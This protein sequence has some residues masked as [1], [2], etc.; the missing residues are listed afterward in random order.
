MGRGES[1]NQR[2]VRNDGAGR[3][4]CPGPREGRSAWAGNNAEAAPPVQ[5]TQLPLPLFEGRATS[6]SQKVNRGGGLAPSKSDP[7]KT[8]GAVPMVRWTMPERQPSR[9]PKSIPA[10]IVGSD[11]VTLHFAQTRLSRRETGA[12]PVLRLRI[13]EGRG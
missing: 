4:Y 10:P 12:G 3:P 11:P 1:K 13:W 7:H 9:S 6:S 5:F 2:G 8:D